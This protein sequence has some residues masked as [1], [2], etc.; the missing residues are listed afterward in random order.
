ML[1]LDMYHT[2]ASFNCAILE[3]EFTTAKEALEFKLPE[4]IY[5]SMEVTD[6]PNYKNSK[7]ALMMAKYG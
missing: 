2:P 4:W 1:E 6:D 3:C 7:I 5:E